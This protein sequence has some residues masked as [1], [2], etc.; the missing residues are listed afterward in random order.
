MQI[1]I[2][3]V[4]SQVVSL[5]DYVDNFY[6]IFNKFHLIND[7]SKHITWYIDLQY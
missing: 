6:N 4:S 3:Y 1:I 7:R 2:Y 5:L